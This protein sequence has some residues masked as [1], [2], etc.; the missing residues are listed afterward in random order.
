MKLG[1]TFAAAALLGAAALPLTAAV[2]WAD[3]PNAV[4]APQESKPAA[5]PEKADGR[6]QVSQRPVGTPETGGGPEESF[7]PAAFG[8]AAAVAALG[9]GAAVVLRRRRAGAN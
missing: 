4:P 7:G 6:G 5:E 3:E 9:G 2:S 8:G 1:R